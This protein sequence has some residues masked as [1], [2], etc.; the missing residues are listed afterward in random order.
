MPNSAVHFC[1]PAKC[2]SSGYTYTR[3]LLALSSTPQVITEHQSTSCFTKRIDLGTL[4]GPSRANAVRETSLGNRSFMRRQEGLKHWVNGSESGGEHQRIG[5]RVEKR[6]RSV[7]SDSLR[8]SRSEY[9]SGS[10]F[11]G[12][13][14]HPGIE[15]SSPALQILDQLSHQ[16]S[17][18]VGK[19]GHKQEGGRKTTRFGRPPLGG[20]SVPFCAPHLAERLPTSL[21]SSP[22]AAG[23]HSRAAWGPRCPGNGALVLWGRHASQ[24]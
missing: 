9:W 4:A 18:R 6:S 22:A 23:S 8:F 7:L 12:D 13:L 3:S 14:P 10:P 21:A 17:P 19:R 2:I 11:P 5:V 16:G 1:S 15:S 24:H 20:D